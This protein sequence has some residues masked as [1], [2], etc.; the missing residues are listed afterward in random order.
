MINIYI[1]ISI[2]MS[3]NLQLMRLQ[4][5]QSLTISMHQ[6]FKFTKL[7]NS[8]TEEVATKNNSYSRLVLNISYKAWRYPTNKLQ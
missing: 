6:V 4:F 7:K 8:I 3:H 5:E 2:I 1:F